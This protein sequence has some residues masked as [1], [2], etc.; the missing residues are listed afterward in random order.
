MKQKKM[1]LE[2]KV[3]CA[4][5]ICLVIALLALGL[6]TIGNGHDGG[7]TNYQT[8]VSQGGRWSDD[9]QMC[10]DYSEAK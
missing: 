1:Y 5:G 8:C 2:E 3:L 9:L 6:G 10:S 4:A 7:P